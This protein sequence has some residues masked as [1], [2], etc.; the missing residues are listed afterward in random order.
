MPG[1][2][3]ASGLDDAAYPLDQLATAIT[4][5]VLHSRGAQIQVDQKRSAAAAAPA[6]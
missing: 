4:K 5:R 6:K 3:H 2:V 1:L